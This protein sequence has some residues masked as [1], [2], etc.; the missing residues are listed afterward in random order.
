MSVFYMVLRISRFYHDP[1]SF[2]VRKWPF[3]FSKE[4]L[5]TYQIKKFVRFFE[6]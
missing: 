1:T 5:R 6:N 3:E 2:F 4:I